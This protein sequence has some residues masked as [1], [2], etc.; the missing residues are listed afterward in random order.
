MTVYRTASY[1]AIP[2]CNYSLPP[3]TSEYSI[4]KVLNQCEHVTMH[5]CLADHVP[6]WAIGVDRDLKTL[7]LPPQQQPPPGHPDGKIW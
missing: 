4:G 3:L 2:Q 5:L 7:W 6:G 1:L